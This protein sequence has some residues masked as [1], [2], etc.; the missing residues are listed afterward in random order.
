VRLSGQ[1]VERGTFSHRHAVLSDQKDFSKPFYEP[2]NNLGRDQAFFSISNSNLSEY[3]TLGFE[4]GYSL[5]NPNALVLWEAQFGDFANGAQIIIDQ[6]LSSQEDKWLRQSGLVLL[7]P[8]GYEGQGPE[9]SSARVERFLQ[10]SN[11]DPSVMPSEHMSMQIQETNWQ[12]VNCST[13]AN[14]FHA[15]R[16]QLHRDFRKPLIV[17]SPKSLLR[18]P[19][20]SLSDM[21][22]G[23]R[24]R[25]VLPESGEGL[26]A[27]EKVRR[28][29]FCSGKVYYDLDK[30]RKENKIHDVAVARVEQLAPFPFWAV[31]NEA[32]R[33]PKADIVWCQEEPMNMGG[34][35][36][37]MPRF[38]TALK[39]NHKCARPRYA[40]R[41]PSAS[42]ATGRP[43][44]HE[45]ELRR[46]L[47]DAFA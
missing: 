41:P 39:G 30:Y 46:F 8:H 15:L 11:E 42:T 25:T 2:L 17:M 16:R 24:F 33:F 28:V 38:E 26:V 32:K 10:S 20:S 1:D 27:A 36:H 23:T 19:L 13:P 29:I 4:L 43:E 6:F 21:A 44:Q 35:A 31:A 37:V 22:E 40:G 18:L 14:Y 47:R 7:L 34:W 5:E 45:R 9:H 12:V 3:A